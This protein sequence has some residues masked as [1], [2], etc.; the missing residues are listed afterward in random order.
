MSNH[1]KC[2]KPQ[3][4]SKLPQLTRNNFSLLLVENF[5]AK[6]FQLKSKNILS[7]KCFET[8]EQRRSFNLF[9]ICLFPQHSNKIFNKINFNQKR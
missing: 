1:E 7:Q 4:A 6:Q 5:C 3:Q 2:E 8:S 9:G